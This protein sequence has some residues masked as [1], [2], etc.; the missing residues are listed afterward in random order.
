MLRARTNTVQGQWIPS[1]HTVEVSDRARRAAKQS[2]EQGKTPEGASKAAKA[3]I[4]TG[5][6]RGIEAKVKPLKDIGKHS[7][8]VDASLP[9]KHTKEL[10]DI[11][12]KK[13]AG[14]LAQ[15]RTGMARING[16]LHG[17]GVSDTDQCECGAAK[18]SVK[19]FLF[20]CARWDRL[21]AHLL[22]HVETRIGDISFCL[23]GRSKS[24]ELDPSLE[25][26]PSHD[27]LCDG[28]WTTAC[29]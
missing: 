27:P 6:K 9:G 4:L 8:D 20:L 10:Y 18:E 25:R 13:E 3:T 15:L 29:R 2:T 7:Q 21:R 28:Y 19:H 22:Q 17:I 5:M 16:Y 26:R 1:G 11:L 12:N 24:L 14:I 23:G